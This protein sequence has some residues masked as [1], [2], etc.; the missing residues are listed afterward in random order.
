MAKKIDPKLLELAMTGSRDERLYI[1]EMEPIYYGI[2]HFPEFFSYPIAPFHYDFTDDYFRM[3]KGEIDVDV[4]IA[5]RESAKTSWKKMLIAHAICYKKKEFINYD[6]YDKDNAEAALFDVANWLQTKESLIADYGD[7]LPR[8]RKEGEGKKIHRIAKFITANDVM[9]QAFS[10]QE[11][12]RGRVFNEKRPDWLIL[13]DI[14]TNKTK[15]SRA[16]IKSII[17]HVNEART[18]MATNGSISILGN[19]I[20][21]DGVIRYI[22]DTFEKDPRA[23]IRNIPAYYKNGEVSWPGKYVRRDKEAIVVNKNMT[24]LKRQVVSL[25]QKER[26]LGKALFAT[27]MLNDPSKSGDLFFDRAKVDAAIE[28]AREPID[29]IAGMKMWSKYNPQHRYG[30]GADTSEGIGGDD[31]ASVWID[32]TCRPKLVVG[33]FNDNSLAPNLFGTTLAR[34]GKSWGRAFLVPEI[35]ASGYATV[36]QLLNE[37][38]FDM[39]QREV[40]NRTQDKIQKEWGWKS[41]SGTKWEVM[42]EFQEAF[43]SGD[44]EIHDL[45]LLEEMKHFRKSDARISNR[46]KGATRHFDKLRAAALAWHARNYTNLPDDQRKK[47]Y[48]SPLKGKYEG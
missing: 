21:D 30:G 2:L 7:L 37:E 23:V 47:R 33:S 17:D 45:G 35:N 40:K 16:T 6:S 10:T 3:M 15:D 11:P 41:V 29:E 26:S 46:E 42:G 31:N 27:E 43:E 20:V 22:I 48:K 18:G 36:A 13:D 1:C 44:L 28:R 9:V 19:L 8:S 5:F 39:Y 25:E 32:F 34:Q 38:Y 4:W 12:V 14:E 24:D